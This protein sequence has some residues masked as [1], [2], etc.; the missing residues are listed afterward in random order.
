MTPRI[1]TGNLEEFLLHALPE[2]DGLPDERNLLALALLVF[3]LHVAV[4]VVS[5]LLAGLVVHEYVAG[6]L[7]EPV[8]TNKLMRVCVLGVELMRV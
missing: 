5:R 3:V 4:R 7:D 1:T 2:C 6:A 8:A